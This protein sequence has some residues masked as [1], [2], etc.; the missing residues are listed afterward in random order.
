VFVCVCGTTLKI[1]DLFIFYLFIANT[2]CSPLKRVF[3]RPEGQ[4][5]CIKAL[6]VVVR[7]C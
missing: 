6:A 4:A 2:P 7:V 1:S 5:I 3:E